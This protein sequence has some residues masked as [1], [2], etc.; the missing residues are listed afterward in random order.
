MKKQTRVSKKNWTGT[1]LESLMDILAGKDGVARQKARKLLVVMGKP[2]VP[3]LI[4]ALQN[5]KSD[6]LRWEAAKTLGA[7]GD[8]R[9]IPQ[10][11]K[12][13]E[14]SDQDVAWLAAEAL[15]KFKKV[16]WPTLLRVLIRDKS[17]SVSLHQ[18][19]HH[20]LRDQKEDGF[21]DLLATLRNALESSTVPES[22]TVAAYD[23]FKRMK[24]KS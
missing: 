1:N 17:G 15:R 9:A 5:S 8:A 18:G 6:H 24:A 10:L 20:V 12:S 14:D 4:R 19:A 11:V 13:L 3:S 21:N 23:I 22:I 2:A 16:A 7:I